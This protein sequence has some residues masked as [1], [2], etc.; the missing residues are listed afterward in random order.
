ML[1]LRP[2]APRPRAVEPRKPPPD[3]RVR[4][5]KRLLQHLVLVQLK[6]SARR[7][8]LACALPLAALVLGLKP[9]IVRPPAIVPRVHRKHMHARRN[10][11]LLLRLIVHHLDAGPVERYY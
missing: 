3:P 2:A 4:L 10:L 6:R 8:A 7:R 9:K 11:L 5:Q 1:L